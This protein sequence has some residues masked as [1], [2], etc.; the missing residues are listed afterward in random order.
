MPRWHSRPLR[1]SSLR[2][3]PRHQSFFKTLSQPNSPLPRDSILQ[4]VLRTTGLDHFNDDPSLKSY[5]EK[6]QMFG[7]HRNFKV[8]ATK[9]SHLLC[10]ITLSAFGQIGDT[11]LG[12]LGCQ[13]DLRQHFLY[14]TLRPKLL[15][16]IS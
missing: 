8:T 6:F 4:P 7:R 10:S 16:K 13:A 1:V 12:G 14:L 9:D 2:V 5:Y 11:M 15:R 3:R